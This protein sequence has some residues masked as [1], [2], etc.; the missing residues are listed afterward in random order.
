MKQFSANWP[1]RVFI[2]D[3]HPAILDGLRSFILKLKSNGEPFDLAGTAMTVADA[4]AKITSGCQRIPDLLL[5]D[6]WLS[7]VPMQT[8]L[9]VLDALH[10]QKIDIPTLTYSGECANSFML[11][12]LLHAGISG[13]VM[14]NV[15]MDVL[16]KAMHTVACGGSYF[17]P[18]IRKRMN[19]DTLGII[20]PLFPKM[21]SLSQQELRYLS[22][23]LKG[24]TVAKMSNE[25]Q[26]SYFTL[27]TYGR[28]LKSKLGVDDLAQ[29]DRKAIAA[30]I[31]ILLDNDD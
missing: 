16:T 21:V 24:Y 19:D 3:D 7:D 23:Y 15:M 26:R 20:S 22:Y 18:E 2:I 14:K 8:G 6:I 12:Q 5:L 17:A 25:L 31:G 4:I 30:M 29:L 11:G 13:Y 10:E 28:R 1:I 9:D 27:A